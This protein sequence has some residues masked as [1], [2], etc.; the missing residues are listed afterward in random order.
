[1]A[2]ESYLRESILDPGAKIVAGYTPIMP[3]FRGQLSEEQMLDLIAY[4]RSLGNEG[5]AQ[6]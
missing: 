1:V 4:I 2:D 5:K 3:V 6:Q